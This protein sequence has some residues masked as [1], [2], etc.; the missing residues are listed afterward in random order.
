M[1]FI[2]QLGEIA[3]GTR[4]KLL[5]ERFMQDGAKIYR[6]Q[7]I[8]FEP[9][10][11]TMF[12][13]LSKRSPLSISEITSELGFTQPAVTQIANILAE[14][15]LVKIVK[16]KYDTR[17]RM[18]SLSPKGEA[19]LP[20]L[21][22][23]WEGFREAVTELFNETGFDMLLVMEKIE[24]A[25]DSKDMFSRVTEKTAQKAEAGNLAPVQ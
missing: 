3:F 5:T 7:N 16:D 2:K 1:D 18:L 4:L 21:E 22:P 19:L 12:Y 15:R 25:L 11:F 8:D 10:C 13:L 6:S 24:K 9:R 17:K 20:V 23:V 14:K